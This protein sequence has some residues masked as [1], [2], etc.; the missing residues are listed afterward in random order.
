[1]KQ[2]AM[3]ILRSSIRAYRSV[4][5]GYKAVKEKLKSYP[6]SLLDEALLARDMNRGM[7]LLS[8]AA[9][10][11]NEVWFLHLLKRIRQRYGVS[12]LVKE[13]GAWDN[14]GAPLLFQAASSRTKH[15]CFDTVCYALRTILTRSGLIE[16]IIA[17][18]QRGRNLM[19]HAA[20]SNHVSV[21]KQ[22]KAI[23]TRFSLHQAYCRDY[24]GRTILHHAAEAGC[25]AILKEVM[26]SLDDNK[27]AELN[28]A[29]ENGRTPIMHVLRLRHGYEDDRD[30]EKQFKM[31][32]ERTIVCGGGGGW[33]EQR[34]VLHPE[35]V[36]LGSTTVEAATE[37]VHAARGGYKSLYLVIE[38]FAESTG[39]FPVRVDQALNVTWYPEPSSQY[40]DSTS[41]I[42]KEAWGWGMLL[43]S[44]ARGGHVNVLDAVVHA[45]K[46][47]QNYSETGEVKIQ[48]SQPTDFRDGEDK[49]VKQALYAIKK[50]G[51]SVYTLA[52]VSGK[53]EAVKWVDAFVRQYFNKDEVW[54]IVRGKYSQTMPI[55][56][57][58]AASLG[59]ED[60]GVGVFDTVFNCVVQV[61]RVDTAS[62]RTCPHAARDKWDKEPDKSEHKVNKYLSAQTKGSRIAP[63]AASA[64]RSNWVMFRKIY[65]LYE[66]R[67]GRRWPRHKIWESF[68]QSSPDVLTG[69][70]HTAMHEH[71]R[72]MYI[73]FESQRV[74][75]SAVMWRGIIEAYERA[76]ATIPR[77]K[78]IPTRSRQ[79]FKLYSSNA[80]D[81]ATA[82]RSFDSLKDLVREGFPLHDDHV[83]ELLRHVEDDEEDVIRIVM[84]AVG[85]ASNPLVMMAG[86][87]KN[88]ALAERTAPMH[89]EG[90]RRLQSIIDDLTNE[91]LE[92]L[93]KTV[94]G[95]GMTLLRSVLRQDQPVSR[96]GQLD[97]AEQRRRDMLSDLVGFIAVEWI[98]APHLIVDQPMIG[99]SYD[100]PA[101]LDPL[102]YAVER[103]SG[104]LRFI[105]SPLVLDYVHIKFS[106]SLPHWASAHPFQPTINQGFY[107]YRDFD[108]GK[109]RGS[110]SEGKVEDMSVD[111]CSSCKCNLSEGQCVAAHTLRSVE[112]PP[113]M[114][115]FRFGFPIL[116]RTDTEMAAVL[117]NN[118]NRRSHSSENAVPHARTMNR[119]LQGWDHCHMRGESANKAGFRHVTLLPGL[120]FSLAGILGKPQTFY[121][122][123]RFMLE[124]FS[125]L[126]FLGLFCSSVILEDSDRIPPAEVAFYVF[127]A[128]TVWRELLEFLDGLPS[129]L[130]PPGRRQAGTLKST[131]R[132]ASDEPPACQ[133]TIVLVCHTLRLHYCFQ[134]PV[135]RYVGHDTWNVLDALTLACVLIAFIA[136]LW[137][138]PRFG[139]PSESGGSFFLAQFFLA[140]SAPLFF[141]RLLLLAQIDGAL[142]PMTQ[143]IWLMMSQTLRFSVFLAIF[144][145]SFALSFQS[146]FHGCR[147]DS[148]LGETFGHFHQA[149]VF[150][151]GAPLGDFSF[152][153]LFDEAADQCPDHSA[154]DWVGDAGTLLLVAYLVVM[155][156]ILFNLLIAILSTAHFEVHKNGEQEFH[157][158]RT[159]LILQSAKAVARRRVAP[160]LNLLQLVLGLLVDT[161]GEL[162]WWLRCTTID[163][164][165][166][167]PRVIPPP[168]RY[169]SREEN[170]SS[171]VPWTSSFL[172][173]TL[174]AFLQ[175]M[176]FALT[177]GTAAV[178]FS[179][180]LWTVSLPLV[181]WNIVR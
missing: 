78:V 90:L 176:C 43:A 96:N 157:A 6:Q 132:A 89:R 130:P 14:N 113:C 69:G 116:R 75:L 164:H 17:F 74:R 4:E 57:A 156:V 83:P 94:R 128:G 51:R 50:S 16:Q 127:V 178:L 49:R 152:Q 170:K 71:K 122:A 87:S 2:E 144:M 42:S 81:F 65:D 124:L 10:A 32:Y 131:A 66:S 114:L 9:Q 150:V 133:M 167:A 91:L 60:H 158:A 38:K 106:S 80:V 141:A 63:L 111:A 172:W 39:G 97:A 26:D 55:A 179:A 145:A 82:N 165:H 36:E 13:L 151:F 33:M 125:Y 148:M 93:P 59:D 72:H 109:H 56:C 143:I 149:L 84:F 169:H 147:N 119:F 137:A 163:N 155:A 126:V 53:K 45:I 173:Y 12:V 180:L 15:E 48:E 153:E 21:F 104:A 67:T 29:D 139:G 34:K 100:G 168:A 166:C 123:V 95:M 19:M 110:I 103:G 52:V 174:E 112:G 159:K 31:L 61:Y 7:S 28:L 1:M 79:A 108:S 40:T 70:E 64:F 41:E 68:P 44:A 46:V 129:R 171:H 23:C 27:F 92:K 121:E 140:A 161:A 76:D 102:S 86:V 118:E 101:Y 98:L 30:L 37:L 181:A 25:S 105:N 22:V 115:R 47:R 162:W 85:N 88:L 99:E 77:D 35:E 18:D 73:S 120:Q 135:A 138:M 11:G 20:R 117:G 154:P 58:A 160:P 136:R 3:Y 134:Y 175:R 54:E 24:T 5:Q 8:C 107:K 177:M 146:L 142:G 62:L